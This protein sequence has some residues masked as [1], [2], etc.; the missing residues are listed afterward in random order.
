MGWRQSHPYLL[1]YWRIFPADLLGHEFE[2]PLKRFIFKTWVSRCFKISLKQH[3]RIDAWNTI[4]SLLPV[5]FFSDAF[6]AIFGEA[7]FS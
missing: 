7:V 1:L 5:F 2:L 4:L 6:T 3:L